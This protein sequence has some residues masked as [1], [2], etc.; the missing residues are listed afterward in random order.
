MK[1]HRRTYRSKWERTLGETG[2]PIESLFLGAFCEAAFEHGYRVRPRSTDNDIIGVQPQK[3][4]GFY[5]VD[6]AISFLFFGAS[7]DLIVELDGHAWHDKTARQVERDKKRER[8]L[9]DLGYELRRF[10]G[11]EVNA[12]A[13]GCAMEVLNLIMDFQTATIEAAMEAA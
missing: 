2:S 11:R 4:I 5:R 1:H 9:M 10:S 7:I 3:T 13:R 12:D 6:L 8:A